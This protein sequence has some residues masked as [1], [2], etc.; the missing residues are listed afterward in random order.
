M[1]ETPSRLHVTLI[2]LNGA[3]GRIDGGV[4]ITIEKP[5][6]ILEAE[7][8]SDE[9]HI[10]FEDPHL[11]TSLMDDYRNKIVIA[12]EKMMEH[13]DIEGSFTFT[14]KEAFPPHSGL[15]S[16]TQL[17]LAV[18]KMI[19]KIYDHEI[20]AFQIAKIVGRGG[21]SGIG[22]ASFDYGGFIVDGGHRS[23]EK[24]DFLPSSVS[25]ASPPPLIARYDFPDDWN[26]IL[27]IPDI[28]SR[29]SG[30]N[31]VDIFQKYCPIPIG[32]VEKLSHILLM[33]MMP[34]VL[35]A[36]LDSFGFVV[37]SI[38]DLGFKKIELKLQ[39]PII[40]KL[41]ENMR[42]AGASGVGMSSFGPTIYAVT[43]TYKKDISKSA[44]KTM[45]ETGGQI[46]ITKARNDG[47]NVKKY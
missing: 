16:G 41:I 28:D 24:P 35:E 2:D 20:P 8:T 4:G 34:A 32:D 5:R 13:L 10:I 23:L 1:I 21:T 17:S 15:G 19:S 29:V 33:K 6:L 30:S 3:Y 26:I 43:D 9:T 47:F 39:K 11:S 36:D 38:Q 27:A 46:V 45:E 14:I 18:G 42:I 12:S 40:N 7:P 44:Q 37:N 25:N 31:E 22:V